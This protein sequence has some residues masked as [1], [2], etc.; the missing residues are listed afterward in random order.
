MGFDADKLEVLLLQ[1]VR[2]YR[3]GDIVKLSKRTG[4]TIT[5][6]ELMDEVGVTSSACA[7]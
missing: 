6:R 5:L 2:L 7:P 4:E 1:M 3:N